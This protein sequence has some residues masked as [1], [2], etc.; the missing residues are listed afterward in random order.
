[1]ERRLIVSVNLFHAGHVWEKCFQ[2]QSASGHCSAAR[3]EDGLLSRTFNTDFGP[4]LTC[5]QTLK[6]HLVGCSDDT[7]GTVF[8][9]FREG[10]TGQLCPRQLLVRNQK[11]PFITRLSTGFC[12][13]LLVKV[14]F[15][16]SLLPTIWFPGHALHEKGL[17]R[18]RA[19]VHLSAARNKA[20]FLSRK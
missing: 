14:W 6:I 9:E 10:M 1:M 12:V 13:P 5:L 20:R 11:E 16:S 3:D 2:R 8:V 18:N 15:L 17:Q 19:P 7:S 4:L